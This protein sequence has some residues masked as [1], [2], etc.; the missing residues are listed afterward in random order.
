MK[1]NYG[2]I[3]G[4]WVIKELRNSLSLLSLLSILS[5]Q[6]ILNH[7]CKILFPFFFSGC[8]RS[9]F[10]KRQRFMYLFLKRSVFLFHHVRRRHS[11][12]YGR[13]AQNLT[14]S[15][16]KS[17]ILGVWRR[18]LHR[19][20]FRRCNFFSIFAKENVGVSSANHKKH[21]KGYRR[22]LQTLVEGA[23]RVL[24]GRPGP[25]PDLP[26]RKHLAAVFL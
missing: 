26:D 25:E 14:K 24:F 9:L 18:T 6:I 2:I 17:C 16:G 3:W 8:P 11:C 7:S 12:W 5:I 20:S 22:I 13:S 1:K 23:H 21:A 10:P 4:I 15:L 19:Y